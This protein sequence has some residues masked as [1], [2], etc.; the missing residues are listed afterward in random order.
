MTSIRRILLIVAALAFAGC[1]IA[2]KPNLPYLGP[3][4][5]LDK[6]AQ[7]NPLLARE[8]CKL[9][10]FQDGVSQSETSAL[11]ILVDI[12]HKN[13]DKF[14]ET[15]DEMYQVGKPDVRKYC[16]P[17]QALF[18]LAEDANISSCNQLINKY[19]LK[20]LLDRCWTT[21]ESVG[22]NSKIEEADKLEGMC[23]D[24]ELKEEIFPYVLPEEVINEAIK[25]P[26]KFGMK[27]YS[28][29]SVNK[30]LKNHKKK[31]GNF[32]EVVDRLNAPELLHHYDQL[33][34]SDEDYWGDYKTNKSVFKDGSGNC[35]D[36]SQFNTFCLSKAG[37]KTYLIAVYSTYGN[38][39]IAAFKDKG[40]I[41]ILDKYGPYH[42]FKGPYDSLYKIPYSIIGFR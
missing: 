23:I 8:I 39:M 21:E 4:P 36:V 3:I 14:D 31:W 35:V 32:S 33:N 11:D 38:H 28:G 10:E 9:P 13:P 30:N 42:Y 19:D 2:T 37:Y 1:A 24:Q 34:I 25:Y 41:Y 5:Q 7:R 12:Y 20:T 15:F 6:I 22:I 26:E 17:L 18:W 29:L 27:E 16:S 40:K